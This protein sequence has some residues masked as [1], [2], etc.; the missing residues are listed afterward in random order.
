MLESF[1]R[2]LRHVRRQQGVVGIARSEA[3]TRDALI[4][5][6][7]GALGWDVSDPSIV[8]SEFQVGRQ[9][10]RVDYALLAN[11]KPI[12]F[13]EAKKLSVAEPSLAQLG[14]YVLDENDRSGRSVRYCVW[15]NGD[16]WVAWDVQDQSRGRIIDARVS[17]DPIACDA[18]GN[19]NTFSL[20]GRSHAPYCIPIGLCAGG[21]SNSRRVAC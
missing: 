14:G 10:Y 1:I 15:T 9:G 17:E 8:R 20:R 19:G 13:L 18:R 16:H 11:G 2:T 6:V 7:L 21:C 5:P 4:N 3:Q 12:A